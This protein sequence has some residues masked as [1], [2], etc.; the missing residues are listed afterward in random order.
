MLVEL[1]THCSGPHWR[2]RLVSWRGGDGDHF[3]GAGRHRETQDVRMSAS[4]GTVAASDLERS[5]WAV[6]SPGV[7]CPSGM[8][9]A[10]G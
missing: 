8:V 1:T 7:E 2:C 6:E 4:L 9:R 5:R 3:A 10:G